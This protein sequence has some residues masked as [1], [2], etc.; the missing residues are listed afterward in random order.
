MWVALSGMAVGASPSHVTLQPERNVCQNSKPGPPRE[1]RSDALHLWKAWRWV[2]SPLPHLRLLNIGK[3]IFHLVMTAHYRKM[4]GRRQA[5]LG[6][7]SSEGRAH[8]GEWHFILK[9]LQAYLSA[10]KFWPSSSSFRH[11][12]GRE[13]VHESIVS[14]CPLLTTTTFLQ[15]CVKVQW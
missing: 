14:L 7:S 6:I 12:V 15:Y 1:A 8:L 9:Y 10:G 5:F 3:I 2:G 11:W 13:F 4:W